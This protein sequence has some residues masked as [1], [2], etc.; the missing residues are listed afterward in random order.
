MPFLLVD[1]EAIR[2]EQ[3]GCCY[4][5]GVAIDPLQIHHKKPSVMGGGNT[6][7]NAVGL[8]PGCHDMFDRFALEKGLSFEETFRVLS[9]FFYPA[10]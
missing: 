8:C 7:D 5:C 10:E 3:G 1:R 9:D 6:R 2:D 4:F